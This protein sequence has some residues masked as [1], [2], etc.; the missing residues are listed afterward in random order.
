MPERFT[1]QLYRRHRRA[2]AL[3]AGCLG[4]LAVAGCV[5]PVDTAAPTADALAPS[6]PPPPAPPGELPIPAPEPQVAAAEPS[7]EATIIVG[8]NAT[9][10][11]AIRR[12]TRDVGVET[13]Y[14]VV[15]AARESSFD[16]RKQARR[17][18]ATGLYQFTAG[19]WLRAV[20]A[21]GERHGLGAYA[22]QIVVDP[23][24]AIAMRDPA[25][26]TRLLRLRADPHLS[27]LMAAELARDNEV[28][29]E[30][31][32]GREVTPAE[33]YI[34]HL[35]GVSEAARVIE[36]ARS[37]PRTPGVRLLPAA[38]RANPKL[39][40]P[41]GRV[42]S[43]DAIVSKIKAY[44]QRQEELLVPSAGRSG[45]RSPTDGVP[46]R[47]SRLSRGGTAPAFSES[48]AAALP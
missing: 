16:P 10:Q 47:L 46:G 25:A 41:L 7:E 29:L 45:A 39:F 15:V 23:S 2:A 34:A 42:A 27:A 14:L 26:Q 9:V 1:R 3:F 24:G 43:A 8:A 11:R 18:S 17:T 48:L 30:Q 40:R 19:T 22:R 21:F 13:A 38:A 5:S 28:R 36:T 6:A 12:A 35:L 4:L 33:V 44:Y 37:A 20:R 31:L 32:L